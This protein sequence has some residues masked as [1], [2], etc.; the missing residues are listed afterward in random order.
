MKGGTISAASTGKGAFAITAVFARAA[1]DC[2][3][4]APKRIILIDGDEL[5]RLMVR[6]GIGVRTR[7]RQEIKQTDEDYVEQEVP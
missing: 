2:V 7:I 1:R 5:A 6:H 3:A 4:P